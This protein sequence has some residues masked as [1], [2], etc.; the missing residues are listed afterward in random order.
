MWFYPDAFTCKDEFFN[1]VYHILASFASHCAIEW[2][3]EL[4]IL[5]LYTL[6]I[7]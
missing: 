6:V 1:K 7:V 4:D 3:F 2:A 5:N